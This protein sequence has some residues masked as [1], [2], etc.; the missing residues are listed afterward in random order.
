MSFYF[1]WNNPLWHDYSFEALCPFQ[2]DYKRELWLFPAT[3]L[4]LT[5]SDLPLSWPRGTYG[6]PMPVAGCPNHLIKWKE[7]TRY[8]DTDDDGAPGNGFPEKSTLA[9]DKDKSYF[10]HKFCIKTD[11]RSPANVAATD[12]AFP[13]G[14]YCVYKKFRCPTGKTDKSYRYNCNFDCHLPVFV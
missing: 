9:G 8:Q 11:F 4:T 13:A 2:F 3:T 14:H 5:N 1:I 7:G 6:L 12:G 10:E